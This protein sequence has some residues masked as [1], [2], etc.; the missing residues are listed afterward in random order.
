LLQIN[1]S[2]I[3]FAQYKDIIMKNTHQDGLIGNSGIE[4]NDCKDSFIIKMEDSFNLT[5]EEKKKYLNDDDFYIDDYFDDPEKYEIY[6]SCEDA[7]RRMLEVENNYTTVNFLD[8]A[9]FE[10]ERRNEHPDMNPIL[11][12]FHIKNF[13]INDY[14]LRRFGDCHFFDKT[15]EEINSNDS[16]KQFNIIHYSTGVIGEMGITDSPALFYDNDIETIDGWECPV[17]EKIE[18]HLNSVF[19]GDPM[20]K[21]FIVSKFRKYCAELYVSECFG[22]AIM[23]GKLSSNNKNTVPF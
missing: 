4:N 11:D 13:D 3:S 5:Y 17:S 1:F 14:L 21:M 8:D 15:T 20:L 16:L 18:L 9:R 23:K 10:N 12:M 6:I 22:C 7:K 2:A 19:S